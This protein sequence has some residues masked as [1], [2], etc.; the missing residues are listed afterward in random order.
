M[1][2]VVELAT[3]IGKAIM[4]VLLSYNKAQLKDVVEKTDFIRQEKKELRRGRFRKKIEA[5]REHRKERKL[6]RKRRRLSE[7]VHRCVMYIDTFC[8]ECDYAKTCSQY[9][10]L[11]R[12]MEDG[13]PAVFDRTDRAIY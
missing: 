13:F 12:I 1:S 7:D 11:V 8:D 3:A 2:W 5:W 9:H 4:N 10:R 6:E